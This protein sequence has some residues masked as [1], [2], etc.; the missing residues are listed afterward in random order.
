MRR[1]TPTIGEVVSGFFGLLPGARDE[2]LRDKSMA[3]LVSHLVPGV[4]P[5]ALLV[6]QP[7]GQVFIEDI[8]VPGG[9]LDKGALEIEADV[10]FYEV[11]EEVDSFLEHGPATRKPRT[12][13]VRLLKA[14]EGWRVKGVTWGNAAVEPT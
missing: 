6:T 12:A 11:K 4:V 8:N 1:E 3:A 14:K 7:E 10:T 2:Q 5:D 9:E 13:K